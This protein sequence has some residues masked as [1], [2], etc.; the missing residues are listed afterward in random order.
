MH[1]WKRVSILVLS[2]LILF[3]GI[4]LVGA[5]RQIETKTEI[6]NYYDSSGSLFCT[7]KVG[8]TG[9]TTIENRKETYNAKFTVEDIATNVEIRLEEVS[10]EVSS[11]SV[12]KG[13]ENIDVSLNAVG[14][15]YEFQFNVKSIPD[16]YSDD[17]T[18]TAKFKH[19]I[20]RADTRKRSNDVS[21]I[22]TVL[23]V[24]DVGQS[25]SPTTPSDDTLPG[26]IL[27]SY[28]TIVRLLPFI[29][30][31]FSIIVVAIIVRRRRPRHGV[32]MMPVMSDTQLESM[33]YDE[34]L[35]LREALEEGLRRIE[36][37]LN[38]GLLSP[39]QYMDAYTKYRSEWINVSRRLAEVGISEIVAPPK[40]EEVTCPSC[41]MP[42]ASDTPFCPNCGEER[43]RC[44]VCLLPIVSG[45][46][47]KCPHCG[48]IA[49]KEHLQEWV[50][51][52]G[53]C[54]NCKQALS[55]YDLVQ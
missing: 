27:P 19:D 36:N 39:Q 40:T 15:S 28:R 32:P 30:V 31:I 45:D 41:G 51:V 47:I 18:L 37:Q 42:Y 46:I 22:S 38:A 43:L 4:S 55:E 14:N 25:P 29:I 16:E 21:S 23:Q 35:G 49:H 50:K 54:P 7:V 24:Y 13:S 3:Q 1:Q 8:L 2:F 17:A 20:Y 52:K 26:D 53:F 34:L 5:Q 12:E 11:E 6:Y 44:I 9:Y 10:W 33:S 48:G